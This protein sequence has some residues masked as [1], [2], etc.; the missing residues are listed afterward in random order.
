[1]GENEETEKI[2]LRIPKNVAV[3]LENSRKDIGRG[4]VWRIARDSRG[5]GKPAAN[6]SL[7]SMVI[8]TGFLA[9]DPVSQTDAEV[10]G[11]LLRKYVQRFAELLEQQK[12][13]K[14]CSKAGLAKNEN[15]SISRRLITIN[16]SCR[17]HTLLL[18]DQSSQVNGW[19]R[20]FIKD[21]TVR[22][23]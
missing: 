6:D 4:F 1:M 18:S 16:G 10:Q 5:A 9:A 13:T 12:L 7:E 15:D 3:M 2:V 17:E 23:S 14:L 19:I 21:V 20:V 11:K 22:R 8:P